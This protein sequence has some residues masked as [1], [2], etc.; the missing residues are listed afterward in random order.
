MGIEQDAL[1]G[2][3]R[4][5]ALEDSQKAM[6]N[7]LEDFDVEKSRLEETHRATLNILED[8]G[9]EKLWLEQ[10]QLA[11]F[12]ILEENEATGEELRGKNAQ[13]RKADEEIRELNMTLQKRAIELES[14]NKE[15]EAFSYSV[16]HDLRTP[17]RAIDGFSQALVEDYSGRLDD[18]GL[19]YLQRMR[20]GAQRMARLIDDMLKLSRVTRDELSREEVDLSVLAQEIAA[21]LLQ[22]QKDREVEF[23]V[24]SG[25][26]AYGDPRL[27]R[28]ALENL[29]GNAWKFTGPHPRARIEFGMSEESGERVYFVRDDGVGFDTT[30]AGKLFGAFQ[31]LHDA[32]EFP[33]TGIGLATV[34]RVINRHGGRIWAE[35]EVDKG[36]TFY[37]TL[38]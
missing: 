30:Y 29:L 32:R 5:K 27:L 12:N 15:L 38:K 18:N 8:F 3:G 1:N 9:E 31:R 14:V 33:G 23:I 21:E 13:L 22:F 11:T 34:Q 28:I 2:E 36:T 24:A 20:E 35:A 7:I 16:S 25:L 17:L 37:F 19:H 4:V 10:L 26:R 6:M